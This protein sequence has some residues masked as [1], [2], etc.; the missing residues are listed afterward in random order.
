MREHSQG[1][2]NVFFRQ[3]TFALLQLDELY[4]NV[5]DLEQTCWL[6]LVIDPITKVIPTR[7]LGERKRE[8]SYA[9]AHD[10]HERLDPDCVPNCMTDGW[11]SYFYALTAHFG[12]WF[13][14]VRARV[15]HWRP[16][17]GFRLAQRVKRT[18]RRKLKYTIRRRA[19]GKM[20][21]FFEVLTAQGF[22]RTIQTAYIER[23]NLTFRQGVA[24]LGRQTW[25]LESAPM[26]RLHVEWFRL[27]YHFARPH[28]TLLEPV[29]GRSGKSRPRTPAMA[30]GL[31]DRVLTVGDLLRMPLIPTSA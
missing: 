29:P 26:L 9:V 10:L 7:H 13:R 28:E 27:Y 30:L 17:D 6:W 1:L 15:D 12:E 3:L 23:L 16:K 24:G 25:A 18:E 4:A 19:W 21:E 14:P 2:H 22:R 8:D 20:S 11:W 5:K 31:T